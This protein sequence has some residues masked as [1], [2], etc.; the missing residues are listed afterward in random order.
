MNLLQKNG[1]LLSYKNL[2]K[3]AFKFLG[4]NFSNESF[5]DI[6]LVQ[7]DNLEND[8][9]FECG[10][11]FKPKNVNII[12]DNLDNE[13][14]MDSCKLHLDYLHYR[15]DGM[16]DLHSWS[17]KSGVFGGQR[18]GGKGCRLL[19]VYAWSMAIPI[20]IN[21]IVCGIV[22]VSDVKSGKSNKY[23]SLFLLTFLYPQW[24]T[25]KLWI[26]YF[27]NKDEVE[28]GNKLDENDKEVTFIEPFCESGL[29]VSHF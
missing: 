22:F 3:I 28:L 29:Q 19:R 8:K 21:L 13:C 25:F 12:G 24:R 14:G 11:F 18:I 16:H 2:T 10:L 20:I 9:T 26:G 27:K 5:S 23:E 7:I 6:K 17:S 15:V 4:V 1:T